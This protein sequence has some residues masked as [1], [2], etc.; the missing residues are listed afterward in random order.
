VVVVVVVVD[1]VLVGVQMPYSAWAD[2]LLSSKK[3][4]DVPTILDVTWRSRPSHR[5]LLL[6]IPFV[7]LGYE[8]AN[9]HPKIAEFAATYGPALDLARL[10]IS[11]VSGG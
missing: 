2:I 3:K 6:H 5:Y 1:V 9:R 4:T 10:D 11:D 7:T 8:Y